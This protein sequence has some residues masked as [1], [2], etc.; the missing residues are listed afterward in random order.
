MPP[1]ITWHRSPAPPRAAAKRARILCLAPYLTL[2]YLTLPYLRKVRTWVPHAV[3]LPCQPVRR[4]RAVCCYPPPSS[5]SRSPPLTPAKVGE[6]STRIGHHTTALLSSLHGICAPSGLPGPRGAP[7]TTRTI[8]FEPSYYE[9]EEDGKVCR[10]AAFGNCESI[11]P[12]RFC[13]FIACQ[14]TA[15][16]RRYQCGV[17]PYDVSWGRAPSTTMSTKKRR[18][19]ERRPG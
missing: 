4:P 14:S 10:L 13:L 3:C 2:P 6:A 5:C 8:A 9:E 12:T 15:T 11:P 19:D 18:I 16:L 7:A 1:A 17:A